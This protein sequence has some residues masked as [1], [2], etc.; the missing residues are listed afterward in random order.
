M[1]RGARE[2]FKRDIR[3]IV[4][5]PVVMFVLAVIILIPSLYAVFNIQATLDPYAHTSDIKVAVVNEDMGSEFNGTQY[6]L[7][8]EFVNELKN[9][10]DFDWQ[11]LDKQTAMDG[12]KTGKYYAVIIVPGNFTEDILSIK[13]SDPHQAQMEYIVNDKLNPVAPRITNAGVDAVQAKINDEVVKTVDGIIFGKLS[14]VG[15]LAK[16]NKAQFLKTKSMINELNGNLGEIDSSLD[17]ANSD[18]TTVNSVWSKV[19]TNLPQI[20]NNADYAKAKSDELAGYIGNDPS[21][22]LTTVQDMEVKVSNL[23]TSLNYMKAILTS[24]YNLTGDPQLKTFITQIDG[25]ITEANQALT[26]L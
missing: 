19:S 8:N 14:D 12:L 3:A 10:T 4:R 5:S 22:A 18:M 13:T 6:N 23:I 15:E 21:K 9:N 16:A 7:G 17:Q 26:V 20:K 1:I 24:L 2:I 25:D 11:F